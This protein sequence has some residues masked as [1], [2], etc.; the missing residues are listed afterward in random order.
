MANSK[1]IVANFIWRF[2]ERFGA[3]AVTLI[4]SIVLARMLNPEI[5]GVVAL[6][7]VIITFLQVFVDSGLGTSLVQKKDADDLDF[8]TVFYFNVFICVILYVGLFFFAP[9]I[10]QFY[11]MPELTEVIRALGLTLVISGVKNIQQ[12]YVSKHLLFKKF[13]FS[14]IGGTIASAVVGIV[15]AYNGYGVWAVVAQHL[16]NLVVDTAIL[17]ITVKWRPKLAF[18]FKRLKGLL[19]YGWKLLV[20]A[21]IE[22]AYRDVRQLIIGKQYTSVDLAVYNKGMQ[23]PSFIAS[24]INT[25]IDGV[26]FPVM[27]EQQNDVV[28]VKNMTRR[29]ISLSSFILWPIMIGLA[30]VAPAFISLLLGEQWLGCVP[31]LQIFCVIYAFIPIHTANLNAIKALGRSDVFLKLEIVKKVVGISILLATMWFGPVY[32]ALGQLVGAIIS[33]FINSFPNRKLLNYKY[34]DQIKDM[35]PS[36]I[37]SLVMGGIVWCINLIGLSDIL[38]LVIQVPLGV[39]I[40]IVG[41]K[42]F[43]LK[44]FDY[45]WELVKKL[46]KKDKKK[47]VNTINEQVDETDEEQVSVQENYSNDSVDTQRG[48]ESDMPN[49]FNGVAEEHKD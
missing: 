9:L 40:Y 34:F 37:L 20:S 19:S 36:V 29:S 44:I 35:L 42:L 5:Y 2:F 10:A 1:N 22:T 47:V 12:S 8:S 49:E 7:T 14:T 28:A 13:F 38:T 17:W 3:Q 18:S 16:T 21:I 48:D 43:R 32:I 23:F 41:A 39:I 33:T 25:A 30:V 11:E 15:M 46:F 4:V 27:S 31:Y 45:A 26:L 6:V 24:N